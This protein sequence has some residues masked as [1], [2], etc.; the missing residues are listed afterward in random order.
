MTET[1]QIQTSVPIHTDTSAQAQRR[2]RR[3]RADRERD[4][5]VSA[6]ASATET[7]RERAVAAK[8][9]RR[10]MAKE[11]SLPQVEREAVE[12]PQEEA[13]EPLCEAAVEVAQVAEA[14]E[15]LESQQPVSLTDLD[16]HGLLEELTRQLQEQVALTRQDKTR[17][18]SSKVFRDFLVITKRVQKVA[19]K[20][21]KKKSTRKG[22]NKSGFMKPLRV[23]K[24]MSRF[25]QWSADELHSRVDV[26]RTLRDYINSKNLVNPENKKEIV[27]DSKLRKL[28]QYN[29]KEEEPLTWTYLQKKIKCLFE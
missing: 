27:P 28:L 20:L 23:T 22:N 3:K 19:L 5:A 1:A 24:E 9:A 10:E 21:T 26:T 7:S 12:Q 29:D 15:T 18:V 17:N 13:G 4:E 16:V 25:A 8:E 2:V 14:F 11:T 6:S